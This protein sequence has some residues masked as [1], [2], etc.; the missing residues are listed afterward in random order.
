MKRLIGLAIF[1]FLFFS[2]SQA[3]IAVTCA[4]TVTLIEFSYTPAF[5]YPYYYHYEVSNP[6]CAGHS[7]S[8]WSIYIPCMHSGSTD[9]SSIHDP[10][11]FRHEAPS[12]KEPDSKKLYYGIKW[13][14]IPD[15]DLEPLE[16][17]K[18]VSCFGFYSKLPKGWVNWGAKSGQDWYS[19]RVEGPVHVIPEPATLSL[20]GFGLLGLVRLKKKRS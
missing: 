4:P 7:I 5:E 8:H 10:T 20:L 15:D 1:G 6:Q 14:D 9:L 11:G 2:L 17:G 19:G 3:A 18:T 13:E 12:F 16:K